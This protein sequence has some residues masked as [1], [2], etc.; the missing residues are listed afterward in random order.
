MKKNN[1]K[2]Y[3]TSKKLHQLI[4][5]CEKYLINFDSNIKDHS[6]LS[7]FSS[8]IFVKQKYLDLL[9]KSYLHLFSINIF[10]LIVFLLSQIAQICFSIFEIEKKNKYRNRILITEIITLIIIVFSIV[11]FLCKKIQE[12]KIYILI[13]SWILFLF[14]F[15][16]IFVIMYNNNTCKKGIF[17]S[18]FYSYFISSHILM[19]LMITANMSLHF[20]HFFIIGFLDFFII[21]ILNITNYQTNFYHFTN[22][23]IL[24][25]LF[26]IIQSYKFELSVKK[27]FDF[28]VEK[29][30][31]Y[32]K[33]EET[34]ENGDIGICL[35]T[36]DFEILK[37]NQTLKNNMKE[38]FHYDQSKNKNFLLYNLILQKDENIIKDERRKINLL[39][40]I[41]E[42]INNYMIRGKQDNLE[43]FV[44]LGRFK[45]KQ[46]T[47]LFSIKFK[48]IL[49]KNNEKNQKKK[50]KNPEFKLSEFFDLNTSNKVN[51]N[52]SKSHI[53]LNNLDN[54]LTFPNISENEIPSNYNYNY[55]FIF[56]LI[57]NNRK[58]DR[59]KVEQIYQKLILTKVS[60]EFNTPVNLIQDLMNKLI[61][62]KEE[63]EEK[64]LN[65][66]KTPF[67]TIEESKSPKD[68]QLELMMKNRELFDDNKTIKNLSYRDRRS[69]ASIKSNSEMC[70]YNNVET[71]LFIKYIA[72]T[73]KLSAMDLTQYI[74]IH[75]T[76]DKNIEELNLEVYTLSEIREF[77][78]GIGNAYLNLMGKSINFI[79]T[80]DN[81]LTKRNIEIDKDKLNQILSNLISNS[82]KNTKNTTGIIVNIRKMK[83]HDLK[84][85]EYGANKEIYEN[86]NYNIEIHSTE[87]SNI[88]NIELGLVISIEDSGTGISNTL[89]N[90]INNEGQTFYTND[91]IETKI[92][93]AE[94]YLISKGLGSG[95]K[96]C[97]K[98]S[99]EMGIKLKCHAK[100][101]NSG[102]IFK[103][104]VKTELFYN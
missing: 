89:I 29:Y 24:T 44:P 61:K 25:A 13:I 11:L 35:T 34:L 68:S 5:D 58:L 15:I 3:E 63:N 40:A 101:N 81:L 52:I 99:D 27:V 66:S 22:S 57:T 4:E 102:T 42:T 94:G 92:N 1:I 38:V 46:G 90:D 84:Y 73:I 32:L 50:V 39:Q 64:T 62:E 85:F 86:N 17:I 18:K 6:I 56:T 74:K 26:T 83:E 53:S 80:M 7:F 30:Y 21:I 45:I 103:I 104:Y 72:D 79:T 69:L 48:R 37:M 51:L 87:I 88:N 67:I 41:E 54:I 9:S 76:S 95:L 91:T 65:E 55:K 28:C 49:V 70:Q 78:E 14:Y 77:I 31:S 97:K 10:F 43:Y 16:T 82:I 93:N 19:I 47:K 75:S 100:T 98:L 20:G 71:F 59:I 23:I 36:D 33:N 96:I 60:N 8:N 2:K 12:N